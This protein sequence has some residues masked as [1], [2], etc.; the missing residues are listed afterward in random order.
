MLQGAT[1]LITGATGSFGKALIARILT[2][3]EPACVV[4]YSRD[5]LKQAQA[6]RAFGDDPRLRWVIGD[7]RDRARLTRALRGVDHVVHTAALKHVDIGEAHPTEFVRTNIT[8]SANVIEA[9]IEA[10]VR[11]VVAL[12]TDKASRPISL[13]GATKL[14]ADKLFVAANAESGPE[15]TRFAVV[16]YGNVLGSRGS[17]V[18]YFRELAAAG[19]SLPLTDKRMTR[20]WSGLGQG[21]DFIRESLHMMT[22]GEL[23]VPRIPSMR[24][25]DLVEAIAPDAVIHEAG[26]RPGETLHEE[27]I[28]PDEARHTV[29]LGDRYLIQPA[30]ASWGFTPPPDAEPVPDGFCYR[31]DSNDHW[32]TVKELRRLLD[33]DPEAA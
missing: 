7:V 15:G 6:R 16:R 28:S 2:E 21:A 32:L 11:K 20:F 3:D 14:V 26:I 30:L 13:Y 27:L 5:E 1:V 33:A 18:P 12:S 10:D 9:A 22:G 8:G 19:R 4:A 31:S 17:V 25:T 29:R 23:Y 24:L